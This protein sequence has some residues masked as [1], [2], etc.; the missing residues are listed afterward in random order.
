[1]LTS[2]ITLPNSRQPVFISK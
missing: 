1:M 2:K